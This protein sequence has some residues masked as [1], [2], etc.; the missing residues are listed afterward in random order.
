MVLLYGMMY[1]LLTLEN[2]PLLI[3]SIFLFIVLAVIMRLSL[4]M[5]W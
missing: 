2:L 1:L 5:H 3:G 4:K